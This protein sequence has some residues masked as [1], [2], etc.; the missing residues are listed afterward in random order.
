MAKLPP[1]RRRRLRGAY[2]GLGKSGNGRI[3][4]ERNDGCRRHQLVEQFHPLRRYGGAHR[5]AS[6]P[7]GSFSR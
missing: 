1:C 3:D 2:D 6:H 4:E 5:K 7:Q